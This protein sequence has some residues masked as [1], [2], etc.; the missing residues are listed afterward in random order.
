MTQP[1]VFSKKHAE[2][3]A[4]DKRAILEEMNLPPAVV[5]FIRANALAL[6]VAVAV[7]IIAI[8]GWEGYGKYTAVQ[9]DRS[10]DTLY[11]AMKADGDQRTDQDFVVAW[12][13]DCATVQGH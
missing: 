9:R 11:M 5:D 8:L 12:F 13:G 10:A 6:Q 2:A 3:M 1:T 7:I 4:Q